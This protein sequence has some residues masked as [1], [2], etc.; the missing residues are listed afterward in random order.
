MLGMWLGPVPLLYIASQ[1]CVQ[2]FAVQNRMA[3]LH[4]ADRL[5][6]AR[7]VVYFDGCLCHR[8]LLA[9]MIINQRLACPG[10]QRACQ[11]HTTTCSC[12]QLCGKDSCNCRCPQCVVPRCA[13]LSCCA[14][15][16]CVNGEA[17][18]ESNHRQVQM[19]TG[20][21]KLVVC[22]CPHAYVQGVPCDGWPL[23]CMHCWQHMCCAIVPVVW[24][25][26]TVLSLPYRSCRSLQI[27]FAFSSN[28]I[29]C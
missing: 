18:T 2:R 20:H 9:H 6:L 10:V 1:P 23:S 12:A 29:A 17:S 19:Y 13:V 27:V 11:E 24:V 3:F 15:Q 26:A 8:M 7:R 14:G 5:G 16:L 25:T 4:E 21:T 22:A 28:S